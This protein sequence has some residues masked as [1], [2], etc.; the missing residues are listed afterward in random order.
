[1]LTREVLD[2]IEMEDT[3]L[4]CV[5]QRLA[6]KTAGRRSQQLMLFHAGALSNTQLK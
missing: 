5:L 4:L 3:E 2:R 1:M 6:L